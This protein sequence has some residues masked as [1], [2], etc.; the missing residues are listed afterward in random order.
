[1]KNTRIF[2]LII[3]Q[4]NLLSKQNK[5]KP[6][7]LSKRK[8]YIVNMITLT[9]FLMRGIHKADS[10]LFKENEVFICNEQPQE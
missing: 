4:T 6:K 2:G 9:F 8:H 5:T 1:M 7:N 10:S 3:G